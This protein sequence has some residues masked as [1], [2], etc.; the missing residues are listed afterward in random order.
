MSSRVVCVARASL[1]AVRSVPTH[2]A[3]ACASLN[4]TRLSPSPPPYTA[5]PHATLPLFITPPLTPLTLPFARFHGTL[6]GVPSLHR[7]TLAQHSTCWHGI[8][9]RACCALTFAITR[10]VY[11]LAFHLSFH[12]RCGD[13]AKKKKKKKKTPVERAAVAYAPPVLHSP[14]I[15]KQHLPHLRMRGRPSFCIAV[16]P[17][18]YFGYTFARR[19][20][21]T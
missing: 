18:S 4:K 1:P 5:L 11:V 2:T 9:S 8:V 13:I 19:S 12:L 10:F 20:N 17:A 3:S 7:L 16:T 14:R 15:W 6:R 21:R